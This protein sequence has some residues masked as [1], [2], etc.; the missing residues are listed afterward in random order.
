MNNPNLCMCVRCICVWV[1][2]KSCVK[3]VTFVKEKNFSLK[4]HEILNIILKRI[5]III[6]FF[7]QILY[8][9]YTSVY[10]FFEEN[11]RIQYRRRRFQVIF[12][13]CVIFP[14]SKVFPYLFFFF[15]CFCWNFFKFCKYQLWKILTNF[16]ESFTLLLTS[17]F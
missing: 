2:K 1:K 13:K 6:C 3:S 4:I 10:L 12:W 16:F 17:F 7:F 5:E 14:V 15:H 11:E 9:W 8:K